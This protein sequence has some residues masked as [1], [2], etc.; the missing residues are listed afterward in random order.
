MTIV[1]VMVSVTTL[2]GYVTVMMD[3]QVLIAQF[4]PYHVLPSTAALMGCLKI[5]HVCASVMMASLAQTVAQI[6]HTL[7]GRLT[8]SLMSL[9]EHHIQQWFI[10]IL[11]LFLEDTVLNRKAFPTL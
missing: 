2:L 5:V 6:Q 9:G 11:Y 10:M 7:T 1:L 4:I 3:G 8:C